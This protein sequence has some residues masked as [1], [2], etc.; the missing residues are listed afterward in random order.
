MIPRRTLAAAIVLGLLLALATLNGNAGAQTYPPPVGSL[1]TRSSSTTPPA[2][3]TTTL[4]ATVLDASGTPVAGADVLFQIDSQPGSGATFSNGLSQITASTDSTGTATTILSV[5]A[6]PGTIV[7][8][9]I[10]GDKTSQ[11]T[12]NVQQAGGLPRTG[13]A[14]P[15]DSGGLAPW[16][17]ALIAA[18]AAAVL[19]GGAATVVRKWRR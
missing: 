15:G 11:Q 2:A 8:K 3:G 18:G 12:L 7:I 16:Q 6:N 5:G 1:S 10:S 13:G 9:A 14:R 19:L 4:F 17:V